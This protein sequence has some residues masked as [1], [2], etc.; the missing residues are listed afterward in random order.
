MLTLVG[1]SDGSKFGGVEAR[2]EL[3]LGKRACSRP[4][5][6]GVTGESEALDESRECENG[7]TSEE[8][9]MLVKSVCLSRVSEPTMSFGKERERMMA[10]TTT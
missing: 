4:E 3:E 1:E 6:V 5:K 2:E 8:L 10:A 7:P 9:L